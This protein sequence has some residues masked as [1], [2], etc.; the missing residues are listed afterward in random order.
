MRPD[1]RCCGRWSGG[2]P[3]A[4]AA[5]SSSRR[6]RTRRHHRHRLRRRPSRRCRCPSRR[7]RR[8]S[9]NRRRSSCRRRRGRR[10]AR[11][12][13]QHDDAAAGSDA[14]RQQETLPS[15][16]SCRSRRGRPRPR[17][18]VLRVTR[19][20]SW[21]T[22]CLRPFER[23]SRWGGPACRFP[24]ATRRRQ[25]P[26]GSAPT[27]PPSRLACHAP[28]SRLRRYHEHDALGLVLDLPRR[29]A[30]DAIAGAD[31]IGLLAAVARDLARRAGELVAVGLEDQALAAPEE[32][33]LRRTRRAGSRPA[34]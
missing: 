6:L 1:E 9:R 18:R 13:D 14:D 2:P 21:W 33:D 7:R 20:S 5:A 17:R 32:V 25:P 12:Q 31:E 22:C 34:C 23:G 16:K 3:L 29:R 28:P 4:G 11:D 24:R 19:R 30:Q 10:P 26:K 15:V 27:P 8:A